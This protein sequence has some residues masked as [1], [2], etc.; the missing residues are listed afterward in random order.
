M[1]ASQQRRQRGVRHGAPSKKVGKPHLLPPPP[2]LTPDQAQAADRIR[3]WLAQAERAV[4]LGGY[5][6]TGKTFTVTE[7]L[8]EGFGDQWNRKRI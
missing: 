1:K 6:G 8:K 4:V 3:A 2:P 5:A 7:L